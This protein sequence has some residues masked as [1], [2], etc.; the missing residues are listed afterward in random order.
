M[1]GKAMKVMHFGLA[2]IGT[3][4]FV[5]ACVSASA[6]AQQVI[7]SCEMED[8]STILETEAV[9]AKCQK[10]SET[11]APPKSPATPVSAS[12]TP[13]SA[14][15]QAA[16]AAKPAQA[17]AGA[18]QP[19]PAAASASGPIVIKAPPPPVHVPTKKNTGETYRDIQVQQAT[20]AL[21]AND[22][23]HGI[24]GAAPTTNSSR[25]YLMIDRS[26]YQK[27]YGAPASEPSQK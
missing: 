8:G 16:H 10:V 17:K 14:P 12:A 19:A 20:N 4:A 7:Y 23:E 22:P 15:K 6:L 5:A 24:V 26:H 21:D 18:A 3:A 11:V 1:R 25:R 9:S 27:A 13:A 2:R